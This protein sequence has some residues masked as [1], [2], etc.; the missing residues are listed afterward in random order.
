MA[1]LH[2]AKLLKCKEFHLLSFKQIHAAGSSSR[3]FLFPIPS[4]VSQ[5]KPHSLPKT[6]FDLFKAR[7]QNQLQ[8]LQTV[9]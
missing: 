7:A 9:H 3:C 6:I 1:F 4:W 8:L 5:P 2:K